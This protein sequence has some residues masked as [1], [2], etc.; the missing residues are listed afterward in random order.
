MFCE[1]QTYANFARVDQ[2][3]TIKLQKPK[4]STGKYTRSLPER[5]SQKVNFSADLA[6][7]QGFF[8]SKIFWYYHD[9]HITAYQFS[10][11]SDHPQLGN[12]HNPATGAGER[13][14]M[15]IH[16]YIVAWQ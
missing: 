3:A 14:D 9:A 10:F 16:K 1:Y 5:R 11:C 12:G 13:V 2:F 7:S 15:I 6:Y 8:T 4:I